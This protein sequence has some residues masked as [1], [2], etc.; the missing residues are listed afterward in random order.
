MKKNLLFA[1]IMALGL[2]AF[3]APAFADGNATVTFTED[4]RVVYSGNSG[5]GSIVPGKT[6][7]K[8]IILNN[9]NGHTADFY[10]DMEA[11][12]DL[13]KNFPN[14]AKRA[15]YDVKLS[16]DGQ[17]LYDSKLGGQGSQKG[18][19]GMNNALAGEGNKFLVS[20]LKK[21]GESTIVF[22][23]LFDGEAFDNANY[24]NKMAQLEFDYLVSYQDPTGLTNRTKIVT[25]K[26]ETRYLTLTGGS[27]Q[28]GDSWVV[29]AIIGGVL[30]LGLALILIGKKKKSAAKISTMAAIVALSF[31][32]FG[33]DAKAEGKTYTVTYRPGAVGTING[34]TGD[35]E[36][37]YSGTLDPAT[38][39][40]LGALKKVYAENSKLSFPDVSANEGYVFTG[41]NGD[42]KVDTVTKNLEYVAD[43]EPLVDGVEYTV[44]YVDKVSGESIYPPFAT[45]G[46]N[47]QDVPLNIPTVITISSATRYFL[48]G[49]PSDYSLVLDKSKVDVSG[50]NENVINIYYTMEARGE[51]IITEYEYVEGDVVTTVVP[52]PAVAVPGVAAGPAPAQ[53]EEV[54]APENVAEEEM[55]IN[56]EGTPAAAGEGEGEDETAMTEI[57]EDG[58]PLSNASKTV[59]WPYFTAAG[60]ALAAVAVLLVVNAKKKKDGEEEKTA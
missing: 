24:A 51:N 29:P 4:E 27:A 34:V 6:Y 18:L 54:E 20:T 23:I 55:N 52:A 31:L 14:E 56:D 8:T 9:E 49:K 41:W 28:T 2:L 58:T 38:A 1:G 21:G 13:E 46:N 42:P 10:M 19:T 7:T 40:P 44:R 22:E 33:T 32:A 3:S 5:S 50:N 47:G 25:Q 15:K 11:A 17:V 16:V 37:V 12:E 30:V 59:L 35:T 48:D 26:G 36:K 43:Y 57:G 39:T 53:G 45:I 60:I